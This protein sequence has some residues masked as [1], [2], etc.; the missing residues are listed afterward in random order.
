M[1]V[2]GHQ[3]LSAPEMAKREHRIL[4]R[5]LHFVLGTGEASPLSSGRVTLAVN[6]V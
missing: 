2:R 5:A 4:A 3:R 1:G 6:G